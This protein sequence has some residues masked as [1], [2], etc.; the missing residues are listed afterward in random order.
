MKFLVVDDS[1]TMRR[2]I[3]NSLLRIGY[4]QVVEAADGREALGRF[5]SS[6]DCIITDWNMPGLSGIE[7]TRALRS[8]MR[9]ALVPIIMV[10]TR[11]SREDII[12]AV[13][14][15]VNNYIL[16]PFTPTELQSKIDRL[17]NP[18]ATRPNALS[19]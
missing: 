15:G 16:K 7:L 6:I 5:D 2:I 11:G 13:D 8:Q 14:A 17:A 3:T 10:T 1:A 9:G 4:D 12:A 19:S 18:L